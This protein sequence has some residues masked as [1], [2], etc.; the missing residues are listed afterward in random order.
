MRPAHDPIRRLHVFGT[1]SHFTLLRAS[2]TEDWIRAIQAYDQYFELFPKY[3]GSYGVDAVDRAFFLSSPGP[4][5]GDAGAHGRD[6]SCTERL[7]SAG[8]LSDVLLRRGICYMHYGDAPSAIADLDAVLDFE[9]PK[10]L[11][12]VRTRLFLF[13]Y[14]FYLFLNNSYSCYLF[15]SNFVHLLVYLFIYL[16]LR[17][18]SSGPPLQREGPLQRVGLLAGYRRPNRGDQARPGAV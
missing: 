13:F 4:L 1:V 2:Q 17:V 16:Y 11:A 18:A 7:D 12:Y 9:H 5:S 6:F 15:N 14:Y 8:L 3:Y 10:F